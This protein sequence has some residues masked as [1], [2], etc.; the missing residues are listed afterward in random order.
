VVI[1]TAGSRGPALRDGA[2]VVE[3]DDDEAVIALDGS[4]EVEAGRRVVQDHFAV[5]ESTEVPFEVEERAARP[6]GRHVVVAALGG[7]Q[8]HDPPEKR[9]PGRVVV[10]D[11]AVRTDMARRPRSYERIE[12]LRRGLAVAP[13]LAEVEVAEERDPDLAQRDGPLASY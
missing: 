8:L 6:Y 13:S 2:A 7:E 3:G 1:I 10:D 5:V 9:R 4:G 12:Q 11:R